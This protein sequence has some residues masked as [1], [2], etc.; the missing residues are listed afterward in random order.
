MFLKIGIRYNKR[1]EDDSFKYFSCQN[2]LNEIWHGGMVVKHSADLMVLASIV[3]P[4]LILTLDF[5][6]L[7]FT[8]YSLLLL[9]TN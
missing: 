7:S 5:K 8:F 2:I 4:P 6:V 1:N 9:D 3:V